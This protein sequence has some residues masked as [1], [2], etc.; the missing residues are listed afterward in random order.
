MCIVFT[1]LG[2][3][4]KDT[5]VFTSLVIKRRT[6][7]ELSQQN[8]SFPVMEKIKIIYYKEFSKECQ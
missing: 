8:L 4:E 6:L 3:K 2:N 1:S 5:Y 7:R